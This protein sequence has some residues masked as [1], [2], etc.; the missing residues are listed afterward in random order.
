MAKVTLTVEGEP[1]EIPEALRVLLRLWE[2]GERPAGVEVEVVEETE[3]TPREVRQLWRRLAEDAR[4]ILKELA[5][6][7]EGY[8]AHEL[9][10]SLGLSSTRQIGGRLASVGHRLRRFPGKPHPVLHER[11][12]EGLIYRLRPDFAQALAELEP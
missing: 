8:P 12:P 6:R 3:W 11:T 1:R 2:A 7:P 9:A 4:R 10:Q 5:H